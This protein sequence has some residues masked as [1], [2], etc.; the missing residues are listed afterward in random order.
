MAY[1]LINPITTILTLFFPFLS[2]I[3]EIKSISLPTLN[4]KNFEFPEPTYEQVI[5]RDKVLPDQETTKYVIN[6]EDMI[7]DELKIPSE[8]LLNDYQLKPI[9]VGTI[10]KG[11][12]T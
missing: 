8:S 11:G 7:I 10:N 9:R 6:R 1:K 5:L 4:V 12:K 2:E 3:S